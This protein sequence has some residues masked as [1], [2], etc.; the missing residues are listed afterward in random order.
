MSEE[1][2]AEEQPIAP[3]PAARPS[4]EEPSPRKNWTVAQ[5]Y[6][7]SVLCLLVGVAVGYLFRG[8]SVSKTPPASAQL[9]ATVPPE[10]GA[11]GSAP[12]GGMPSMA[13]PPSP[14]QMKSMADKKVAPLLE[15]LKQNPD[16]LVTL[17]K[18]GS[19]YFAA[20]QFNDAAQYFGRA[21]AVK[22]S[23]EAFTNVA[24]SEV[25][26]GDVEKAVA[27]FNRAL[28]LDAGYAP[29]LFNLGMVKWKSQNDPKGAVACWEKLIKMNPKHPH[30]DEVKKMIAR[31]KQHEKIAPGTKTDKPAM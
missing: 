4:A 14:D 19:Y 31:A 29:A 26:A 12:E 24:N 28:E 5:V 7:L 6:V 20:Q 18:V 1:F 11:S 16:D 13:N 21:A 3:L 10:I 17:N 15:Q 25:Y 9:P 27:S 22:P 23:A 8:S 2:L 30:L